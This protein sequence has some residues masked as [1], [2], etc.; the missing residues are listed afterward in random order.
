MAIQY[1]GA[2]RVNFTF[3]DAGT[4][5]D[6]VNKLNAQLKLS[7]W[8][9]ISGD[10]TGDVLMETATGPSGQKVR[11]RLYDP[12]AGNCA[13]LTMKNSVGTLTS[14]IFYLL[15]GSYEWR[16]IANKYQF[17]MFRTGA[18]NRI[19]QRAVVMGGTIWIPDYVVATM[20]SDKECG[21]V[22]GN[23]SS[24]TSGTAYSFRARYGQVSG[25]VF[26]RASSLWTSFMVNYSNVNQSTV[27]LAVSG[28][29]YYDPNFQAFAWQ[30]G[31]YQQ[32]EAF[33]C[34]GPDS[35]ITSRAT[36][37]G[38]IWDAMTI[39]GRFDGES[40]ISF[41]GHTFMAITDQ[42]DQDQEATATLYVALD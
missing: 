1:A 15:P 6:L 28:Q 19:A 39:T 22:Q 33:I 21:W 9:A 20:G 35:T 18:A 29:C 2:P 38:Q 4:R 31:S 10:G 41:A 5:L 36:W 27:R 32:V 26:S 25:T 12:G 13:Q 8:T 42:C 7:G 3:T 37:K 17:F 11:F 23:G 30:G 24:D 40:T 14:Q 16:I 34:W